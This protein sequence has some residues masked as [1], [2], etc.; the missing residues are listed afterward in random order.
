MAMK[1]ADKDGDGKLSKD[2]VFHIYQQ[3]IKNIDSIIPQ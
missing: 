3:F 2:E 1:A